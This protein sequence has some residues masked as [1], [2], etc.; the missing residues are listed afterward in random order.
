MARRPSPQSRRS[1]PP[2]RRRRPSG[3]PRRS[4]TIFLLVLASITIITLDY[5][6]GG[7]GAISALRRAAHD[8][9]APVEHA[10]DG[11]VRPIGDFF[12]GAVH[13]GAVE[14][15]NRKLQEEIKRAQREA[16]EGQEARQQLGTLSRLQH[17]PW[18]GNVPTTTAQVVAPNPSDF[19]ATVQLDKGTAQGVEV[20][21]PVVGGAGLL[22][23]VT[24]S[25]SSGS[26]VRLVTDPSEVVDV[27]FG[28]NP[29]DAALQGEGIGK[30][31]AL[32]LVP[33]GTSL[34]NGELLYTS[35][36]ALSSFPSGIP[37]AKVK[38]FVSSPSATQ[39]AVS[40]TPLADLSSLQYVDVMLWEPTP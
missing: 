1:S 14:Q 33:P 12:A 22:G 37:V 27:R 21:M 6:G 7:Q 40:A 8:T 28:N 31:L 18:V 17:L 26:T 3:R 16:E 36:L 24:E 32:N 39:E 15:Q 2:L 38:R 20:G 5:R 4:F 19:V 23:T 13:Y 10:V 25:W 29:T 34:H 11:V 30:P 9:F 35:G